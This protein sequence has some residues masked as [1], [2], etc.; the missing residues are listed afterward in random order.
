V[1]VTEPILTCGRLEASAMTLMVVILLE[2]PGG[3]GP[4]I[5]KE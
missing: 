4:D 1:R 3:K 2:E 5:L